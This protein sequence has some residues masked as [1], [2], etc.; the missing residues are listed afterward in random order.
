MDFYDRID[1]FEAKPSKVV[2]FIMLYQY[3]LHIL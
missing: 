1:I 3:F 2:F